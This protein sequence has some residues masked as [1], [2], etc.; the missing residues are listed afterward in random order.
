MMLLELIVALAIAAVALVVL[1]D[2]FTS[3]KQLAM[4][5]R[6]RTGALLLASNL[7][8]RVSAH[9]YGLPA[10]KD[11]PGP[12]PPPSDWDTTSAPGPSVVTLVSGSVQ[13]PENLRYYQQLSFKN[14]SAV[15]QA[16][17]DT[18]AATIVVTWRERGALRS[19]SATLLLRRMH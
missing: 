16:L 6:E 2:N 15:A 10:P 8:E 12:T 19:L 4:A 11:W 18:D 14:G 17:G 7:K 1:L 3:N 9:P 13:Q 5:T